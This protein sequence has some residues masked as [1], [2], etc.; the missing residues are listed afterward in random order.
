MAVFVVFVLLFLGVKEEGE[1]EKRS[2]ISFISVAKLSSVFI[3][4]SVIHQIISLSRSASCS[5]RFSEENIESVNCSDPIAL[6]GR[7][8]FGGEEKIHINGNSHTFSTYE[9]NGSFNKPRLVGFGSFEIS[10]KISIGDGLL[11]NNLILSEVTKRFACLTKK[12]SMEIQNMYV[13]LKDFIGDKQTFFV[14]PISEA[15]V[16][17][18]LGKYSIL[19]KSGVANVS[20]QSNQIKVFIIGGRYIVRCDEEQNVLKIRSCDITFDLRK[21]SIHMVCVGEDSEKPQ[22]S[23][24]SLAY[25]SL[26][27]PCNPLQIW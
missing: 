19:L 3:T 21:Y 15:V 4:S 16:K 9:L 26:Y 1:I 12:K 6:E 10:G 8:T 17:D 22:K 14:K 7:F 18:N 25:F 5:R 2:E 13:K 23:E 11:I 20:I 24:L 27:N